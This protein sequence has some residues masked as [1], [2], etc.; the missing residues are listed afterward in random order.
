MPHRQ[1]HQA[2]GLVRGL[3]L[4][5][6]TTLVVGSALG[7]GIFIA[8]SLMAGVIMSPS[9][10]LMLWIL[11]G[12][13]TLF[14]A[15]S[16]GELSASMPK[17]GGQYV[18]LKEAYSPLW[19]FLYGW[20]VFTVIQTG[21]I[22]AVA[23][24]F[25]KYLG[26]FIPYLSEH[27]VLFS[28]SLGK[29]VLAFNSAQGAGILSII[30]L[31]SINCFGIRIGA[32]VQNIFT[33]LKV[34]AVVL[35]IVLGF[36]LGKG[37]FN[38]FLPLFTPVIPPGVQLGLFAALAVAMSK[39]LFAYDGWSTV[40]FTAEEVKEAHHNLPRSM[41]MG[42]VIVTLLY[43]LATAV[44]F[45]LVPV[46]KAAA[47]ADNRIAAAAAQVIFGEAGLLI[48]SAAVL[49]S[50]FGCNN[51]LILGGPRVYYAM[52]RDGLFFKGLTAI[53]H[54]YHVPVNALAWQGV[55]ACILTLSG[56]YSD[57]LTYIAF[58]SVLF[59]LM[60]VIG[61][62]ILRKKQPDLPR[63]YRTFGYPLTPIIYTLIGLSFLVFI[64]Q[65]DPVNSLKGL[66]IILLGLPLFYW[67]HLG[68]NVGQDQPI[69]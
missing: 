59:N 3:N 45:Y 13:F 28:I 66:G 62:F 7:S 43:A 4:L 31:T 46:A 11:A 40:T 2:A 65:G 51:G 15:M 27:T 61:V 12:I 19:G 39:A 9:I 22:A 57:L 36:A 63:P 5:S 14:G 53:H 21:L 54:K 18:F 24:A 37:S 26:S 49:I 6:A 64:L 29:Y 47:V 69:C 67:F 34:A 32:W 44:Y 38:N 35:L 56:T 58:A 25:A 23:V 52:A 60:T 55:W 8:P 17:A 20:T 68:R 42:T 10:I 33:F 50:T 48:I 16:Y 41:I 1:P 30:L